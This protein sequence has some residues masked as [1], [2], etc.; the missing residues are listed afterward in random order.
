M[1][2]LIVGLIRS[3][4]EDVDKELRAEVCHHQEDEEAVERCVHEGGG[5]ES[6]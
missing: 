4:R 2:R 3:L 6:L 5:L 1:D